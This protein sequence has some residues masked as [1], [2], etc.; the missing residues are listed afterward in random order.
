MRDLARIIHDL[1]LRANGYELQIKT[2][3]EQMAPGLRA[4][5]GLGTLTAAQILVAWS[6]A[7]R[8]PTEAAFAALAGVAPI[9]ASSGQTTRHRLNRGGD[10][11]LNAALHVAVLTRCRCDQATRD[12]LA[13][14]TA[15]GKTRREI[16]RCLKRYLARQL[17]RFLNG[18]DKA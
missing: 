5:P 17:F 18:L 2:L 6:H 4:Q 12:Y 1:T 3:V 16:Q 9:P 13:R 14:R 7:G 10:R 11:K 15:E 8:L